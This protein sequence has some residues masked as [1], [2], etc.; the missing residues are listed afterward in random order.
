V[1]S[2]D[3][4]EP[5][6]KKRKAPPLKFIPHQLS[7]PRG[8]FVEEEI[9]KDPIAAEAR[10][11]TSQGRPFFF[12]IDP[13]ERKCLSA[14]DFLNKFYDADPEAFL[15]TPPK[16]S[17]LEL[18]Y[19]SPNSGAIHKLGNL[20]GLFASASKKTFATCLCFLAVESHDE[21]DDEN[22]IA[23]LCIASACFGTG[24][25]VARDLKLA[26]RLGFPNHPEKRDLGF[27][28]ASQVAAE[29]GQMGM[30]DFCLAR[31]ADPRLESLDDYRNLLDI[32]AESRDFHRLV[33]LLPR[34]SS[35]SDEKFLVSLLEAA[36]LQSNGAFLSRV[37]AQLEELRRL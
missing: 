26:E 19:Q 36:E 21:V 31:G 23:N 2:S 4:L 34:L 13:R 3:S 20:G 27:S 24:Q 30:V 16:A 15:K 17:S 29:Q 12:L 5:L 18:A 37:K 1:I 33:G 10:Q 25:V 35:K 28:I 8:G 22:A 11:Y 7:F 9:K 32:L 14:S 6:Q